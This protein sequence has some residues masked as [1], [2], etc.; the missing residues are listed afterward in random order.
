MVSS[1]GPPASHLLGLHVKRRNPE[2]RW[3]ADFRDLWT[4]NPNF[5]WM[6]PFTCLEGA[7]ERMVLSRA[8][9]VVTVSEGLADAL[10]T[11]CPAKVYVIE[12]GFDEEDP[13][14]PGEDDRRIGGGYR[15]PA[16][17]AGR[18]I[19]RPLLP[20]EIGGAARGVARLPV[21]R[22]VA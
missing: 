22:L 1:S 4:R 16:G 18:G 14:D 12:N 13:A 10:R 5:R 11:G 2:I 9:A 7:L 17:Y 15:G 20:E 6:F 19:H 3:V 21:P 8:D